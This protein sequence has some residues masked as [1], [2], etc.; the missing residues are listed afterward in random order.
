VSHGKVRGPK[1]SAGPGVFSPP[2][3]SP[4]L[5]TVVARKGP[6][7]MEYRGSLGDGGRRPQVKSW[8]NVEKGRERGNLGEVNKVGCAWLTR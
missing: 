6:K 5:I 3:R 2:Y 7:R 1:C 4:Q 8:D